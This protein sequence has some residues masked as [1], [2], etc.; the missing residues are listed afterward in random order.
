MMDTELQ[1]LDIGKGVSRVE[2]CHILAFNIYAEIP[3]QNNWT[4]REGGI[5]IG[6]GN[7]G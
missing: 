5:C 7:E 1:H 4:N 2:S 6:G 3:F